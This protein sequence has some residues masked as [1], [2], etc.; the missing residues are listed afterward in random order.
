MIKI[1]RVTVAEWALY[2]EMRLTSLA[3]AP[4]AYGWTLQQAQDF[5]AEQWQQGLAERVD[6][7][8]RDLDRLVGTV[9]VVPAED[10][11]AA[12]ELTSMWVAPAARGQGVAAAL[13]GAVL[14]HALKVAAPAVS[15][16]VSDGNDDAERLYQRHGFTRT[17][18]SQ[19]LP[20]APGRS[21]FE[22][23]LPAS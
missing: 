19:P 5:T 11:P 23:I 12:V 4:Y 14:A 20:S 15:A 13:V 21:E 18:R 8:A 6:F 9:G 22:M 1:E 3:E 2:R 7:F 17:G 16:W 10:D